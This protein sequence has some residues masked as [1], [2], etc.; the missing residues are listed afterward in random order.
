MPRKRVVRHQS[1]TKSGTRA[2]IR[3]HGV[4]HRQHFK[5][6]TD[7]QR[8]KEWLLK[9]ELKYRKPGSKKT[10]RFDEDARAYLQAVSAM[11]T[12]SDRKR[13]IDAWI[14]IFG[15][16]WRDRITA[17]EIRTQLQTW[18]AAGL[19][20]ST[21]NHRRTALQHLF[22]V[23]DGKAERNV[24]KDVP[25]FAEPSP[26]P[27]AIAPATVRRILARMP[28]GAWKARAMV[29]AY[30]GIPHKLLG[31]IGPSDVNLG[32]G[33][34]VVRERRKGKGADARIVPLTPNGVKAFRMMATEDAW[35][36]FHRWTLRRVFRE[37]CVKAKVDPQTVRVYDLRH[38]FG[39]DFLL[40]TGDL[41]ATQELLGHSS[42]TLTHRYT[43]AA[44]PARLVAAVRQY[45]VGTVG[46]LSPELGGTRRGQ[47]GRKKRRIS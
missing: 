38:S 27:R 14:A 46:A 20:A 5:R 13:D 6:G 22:T 29:L 31:Q 12:Y 8:I 47:A 26:L 23:L 15:D 43:L 44:A 11:P 25:K 45:A 10:G 9:T 34:V 40:T 1:I 36:P 35:G 33:T 28:K 21:V 2:Q 24:V 39:T 19:A 17:D 16:T 4:L 41:A 37:A 3:I 42:A 32:A 18:K 30:V 7:P